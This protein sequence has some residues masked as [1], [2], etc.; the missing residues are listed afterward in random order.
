LLRLLGTGLTPH[1]AADLVLYLALSEN[2]DARDAGDLIR[3]SMFE[4]F[5]TVDLTDEQRAAV[6]AA[7]EAAPADRLEW[8]KRRLLR[9]AEMQ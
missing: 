4:P 3:R 5:P 1:E 8:A 9:V 6:R 2:P 7:I